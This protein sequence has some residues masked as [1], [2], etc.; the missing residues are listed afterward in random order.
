V[1]LLDVT[2]EQLRLLARPEFAEEF[3]RLGV[4]VLRTMGGTRVYVPDE[5]D[6][7][8]RG[9]LDD[10]AE[11]LGTESSRSKWEGKPIPHDT[12]WELFRLA[13]EENASARGLAVLTDKRDNDLAFVNRNKAGNIVKWVKAHSALARRALDRHELPRA[14][15]ATS[16]GVFPPEL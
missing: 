14:F 4:R 8:V 16:D 15:R 9:L 1:A 12:F 3:E 7:Y 13:V 10:S 5:H 11:S 6:A 2:P